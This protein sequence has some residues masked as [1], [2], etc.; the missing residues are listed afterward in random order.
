MSRIPLTSVLPSFPWDTL[1]PAKTKASAHPGGIVDLSVGTPVDPVDPTI[2]LALAESAA[3]PGYPPAVGSPELR[4]AI[5]DALE[6]RYRMAGLDPESV[7]PVIGTKEAIALLP[8]L[9]GLRG[10]KIIIPEIAYPTYEVAALI[11]GCEPIRS[12]VPVEGAALAF[13]N[14][15]SNPTGRVATADELQAWVN[16]SRDTGC[17]VASDECYLG[18][19][20]EDDKEPI[21]LLD[22]RLTGT[23]NSGLI[24]IHSLSKTSSLASYR[25]GYLAGDTAVIAELTEARKHAGLM[26][27]GPIQHAMIAALTSDMHEDLQR[28][29]YALRRAKLMRAVLSAGF[30]V[31]HSEAGLYLWVTRGENCR[32]TVD[33]FAERGILVAPGDFYGEQGENFVRI[34]LTAT[35]ERIDEAVARLQ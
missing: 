20:W 1:A 14:S 19:A 32:D 17:I 21:S 12:D 28:A 30:T 7:L 24:A 31:E 35:D 27:P 33:W 25:A 2:Q 34:A 23:D 15:P 11:A 3:E 22:E 9:L 5:V 18:L 26:V 8:T 13:I 4:G 6:R 10:E 16:F 29:I